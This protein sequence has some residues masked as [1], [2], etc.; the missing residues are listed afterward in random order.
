MPTPNSRKPRTFR[1]TAAI[2]R[3]LP[4]GAL[5]LVLSA[6]VPWALAHFVGWPLP[7]H[8]PSKTEIEATLLNPITHR[9]LLDSLAV[10]SWIVWLT[11]VVDLLQCGI[12]AARGTTW[13][14]GRPSGPLRTLAAGLIG[15]IVVALLGSRAA[16][17]APVMRPDSPAIVATAPT[18]PAPAA[19]Q[20]IVQVTEEVRSPAN[21][22]HDSLW[23]VAERIYGPGNGDRWPELFA[24]NRGREQP[25]GHALINPN[26][27]RPGW[28]ITAYLPAPP[29][30]HPHDEPP[31]HGPLKHPPPTTATPTT[32]PAPTKAEPCLDLETGAYVS[33]SLAALVTAALITARRR[34]RR[35]YR[36]ATPKLDDPGR[37]PVVRALRIAHDSMTALRD[38][39]DTDRATWSNPGETPVGVH[40]G[41][42]IAL[43]IARHR[44]LGLTGPG[45]Y[46]A[47]R[48]LILTLLADEDSN[49][50]VILPATEAEAVFGRDLPATPPARLRI[51]DTLTTALDILEAELLSRMRRTRDA[52]AL[53]VL[54]APS[55]AGTD[56]RAQA[57]LDNGAALNLAGILLGQW[58]AGDTVHVRDD[59]TVSATTPNLQDQ[60]AGVRLFTLPSTD[61]SDLL[62]LLHAAEPTP[63]PV[64]P[65]D[66]YEFLIPTTD[67]PD[68]NDP[69][70][71]PAL[72]P[73]APPTT[74]TPPLHFQVLGP[75]HL[76]H[77]TTDPVDLINV[78]APRQRE[79]LVYLALHRDGCRRESLAAALWPDAPPD[80]PH[81][82]FHA[83]LSQLR[84]ALRAAAQDTLA[85]LV[86]NDGGHYKL[87]PTLATV[88]LWQ[89]HD[90]LTAHRQA[91]TPSKVV[92]LQQI[93]ELYRGDLADG[94]T[95]DWLDPTR[96]ALR[97]EVL[98]AFSLTI[99]TVHDN[100]D[101]VLTLLEQARQMDPYN[102]A[103]YRDLM[104][105]Q[106]RLGQFDTIPRTLNLLTTALGDLHEQP[107]PST[108][109][110]AAS[111]QKL[112]ASQ[113]PIQEVG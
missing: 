14:H 89:L 103:I 21:G 83:T 66:E 96:E 63:E 6:G 82:S 58:P 32:T 12:D 80:R 38:D 74:T 41:Q 87:D 18:T 71:K 95:A 111:L 42:T 11:F 61:A 110:L 48:A 86:V 101:Q 102:E 64:T 69:G 73:A 85:G 79:I 37:P 60:L 100:P 27:I 22:I 105:T 16:V 70:A 5:L 72:P 53:L 92:A 33:A 35:R 9:L 47:I 20:G 51:V 108:A 28:K 26:L 113:T 31:P 91:P 1:R 3:G 75:L 112:H 25:D 54:V 50:Q 8:L 44:G 98:D 81:N 99:R 107:N 43:N 65:T 94:I 90:A 49:V 52:H 30:A 57:I 4:A 7:D 56:H 40:E 76:I 19:P 68:N 62:T 46:A 24:L 15:A 78:M 109:A 59:G 36:P 2:V 84:R 67:A 97:R 93:A 39:H 45:A 55:T 34:Q 29:Q 88:D 13:Q 17:A 23:R 106:A 77:R 104:R 10:L